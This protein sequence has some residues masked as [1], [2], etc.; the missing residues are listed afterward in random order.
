MKDEKRRLKVPGHMHLGKWAGL[1]MKVV[2]S[3]MEP[4][5]DHLRIVV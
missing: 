3:R 1:S 2:Q 5:A 4:E